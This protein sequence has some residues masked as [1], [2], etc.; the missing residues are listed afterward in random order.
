MKI[1]DIVKYHENKDTVHDAKIVVIHGQDDLV[2]L[3][4]N[5]RGRQRRAELVRPTAGLDGNFYE[6]PN[7]DP[8]EPEDPIEEPVNGN[9][10]SN[11]E[12]AE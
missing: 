9:S 4:F 7:E 12:S 2:T 10:E 5:V 8:V 6:I 1:G 11:D 3:E